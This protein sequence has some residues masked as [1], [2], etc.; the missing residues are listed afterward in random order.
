MVGEI[1]PEWWATSSGAVLFYNTL[2]HGISYK[3]PGADHYEEQYRSRVLA[4]LKRRAKSLGF[5]LQAVPC[6][7]EVAVS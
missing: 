6:G 2:R 3:D 4:N 7:P 5:V 1:I